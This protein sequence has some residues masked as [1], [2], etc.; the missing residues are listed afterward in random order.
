VVLPDDV[1][2][3]LLTR[4]LLYTAITRARTRVVIQGKEEIVLAAAATEVKRA[5]GIVDRFNQDQ[6]QNAKR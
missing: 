6:S 2:N 1:E 3:K 5:S 4:E